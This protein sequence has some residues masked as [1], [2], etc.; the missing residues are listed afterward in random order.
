MAS[1][2]IKMYSME[3]HKIFN[4][5]IIVRCLYKIDLNQIRAAEVFLFAHCV[6]CYLVFYYLYTIIC[7]YLYINRYDIPVLII[8]KK[9]IAV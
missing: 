6:V 1:I 3:I 4:L 9:G 5:L 2:K 8:N 7:N